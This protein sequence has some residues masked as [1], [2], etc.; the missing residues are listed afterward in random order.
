MTRHH[1]F[2]KAIANFLV[3]AFLVRRA[4]L[5]PDRYTG[6]VRDGEAGGHGARAGRRR[7]QRGSLEL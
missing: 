2:A 4:V 3:M 5:L 7:G 6:P 1:S